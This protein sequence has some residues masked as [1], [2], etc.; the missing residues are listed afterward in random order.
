MNL[1]QTK[2]LDTES[3]QVDNH[4]PKLGIENVR[5]EIIRGLQSTPKYISS[6]F[7]YDKVGSKLFEAI[8]HLDEYYPTR[9]E[10]KIL[11]TIGE[12]F[13]KNSFAKMHSQT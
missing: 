2:I 6:K 5:D 9:T 1:Q 3:I 12:K 13:N 11:S 8:T 7:F 10:K 4:L